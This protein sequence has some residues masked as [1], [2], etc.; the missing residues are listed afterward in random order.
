MSKARQSL[1]KTFSKVDVL[2][3]AFGSMIGWGW[4]ALTGFWIM[5]AGWLGASLAYV[6]GAVMCIFVGLCYAELT[7]AIPVAGGSLAYC[8]RG[9]GYA[10]GW[11]AV[12]AT[13]FAYVGVAAWEGIAVSTAVDFVV[14]IPKFGHLWTLA[15]HDVYLSWSLVGMMTG[16]II[17]AINWMGSKGAARLQNLATLLL[18]LIGVF[19]V[20]GGFIKGDTANLLTKFT[21]TKGFIAILLMTPAM[22]IGF[23]IIP[24][25]AEEMNFPLK[26]ISKLLI[27]SIGL[28]ASWYVLIIAGTAKAAPIEVME[29]S[30]VPVA[31]AAIHL[32]KSGFMG[33]VVIFGALCGILTSWNGFI[34]G[35]VRILFA[36]SRAKMI[37]EVFSELHP[38]TKQPWAAI[39]LVGI[40]CILSPLLGENALIWFVNASSFG[41]VVS[42]FLVC[43]SFLRLRIKEPE[44]HRP[45]KIKAGKFIGVLAVIISFFFIGLYLPFSPGSLAWPYEWIMVL[46]WTVL[47][48][49]FFFMAEKRYKEVQPSDRELLIFGENLAR[50]DILAGS[51]DK[52]KTKKA[53]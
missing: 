2:S 40:I 12:W 22:F 19:F 13:C 7:P 53:I 8:Y 31:S 41:I 33:N 3:L 21:D 37:P 24:Q 20:S 11:I 15:G 48:I 6:V 10:G 16:A 32:F 52:Q 36:M 51:L 1:E 45:I 5:E 50:K 27:F 43:L 14:P 4:V 30:A 26:E 9:L 35:G 38:K 44:L 42:Y 34:M 28:S 18:S 47:G 29:N 25:S 17:I 23:D 39:L 49:I 46:G